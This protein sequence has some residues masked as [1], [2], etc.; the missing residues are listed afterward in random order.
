MKYDSVRYWRVIMEVLVL[1]L[2][3][4]SI[5]FLI[6]H[7]YIVLAWTCIYRRTRPNREEKKSKFM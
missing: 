1:D 3:I 2:G 4:E 7:A 5:F 6:S